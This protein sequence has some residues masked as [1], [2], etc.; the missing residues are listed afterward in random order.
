MADTTV[1]PRDEGQGTSD[2]TRPAPPAAAPDTTGHTL[3]AFVTGL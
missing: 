1:N 2:M 3:R